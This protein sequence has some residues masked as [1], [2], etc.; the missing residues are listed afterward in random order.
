MRPCLVCGVATEG[1]RCPAHALPTKSYAPYGRRYKKRARM[2][3][4]LPCHWC[5]APATQADHLAPVSLGG[6]DGP[7]VPA[8]AHCNASRGMRKSPSPGR[9]DTPSASIR[10]PQSSA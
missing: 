3:Y 9:P 1:S 7:L 2:L 8:C 5:G 10:D 4:G 6:R